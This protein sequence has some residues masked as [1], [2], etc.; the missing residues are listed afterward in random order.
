M[1]L[2]AVI[3]SAHGIQG[4]VKVK[5]FTQSPK[6]ILTYGALRDEKG[7]EFSLKFLR[8]APPDCLI[9]TIKGIENRNKAEALRGTKL[10]VERNQLPD[11]PEEEFYHTDLIGLMVQDLEGQ[12]IGRLRAISNFGAGDFLET[13]GS[14]YHL[15]T[16]P[17]TRV[18]VPIIRLPTQESAGCIQ[19]DRVFLLDSTTAQEMNGEEE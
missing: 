8:L 17:F 12:D 5:T 14:D 15:Y 10:Y 1:I 6:S 9:V 18:A 7:Q 3:G 11:L 19:I 16:I 2:L 13:I 4:A